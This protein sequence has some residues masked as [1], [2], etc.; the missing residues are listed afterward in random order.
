MISRRNLGIA[1]RDWIL[2]SV[3]SQTPILSLKQ[4]QSLEELIR[5]RP[6]ATTNQFERYRDD[7]V[8]FARDILGVS[9]WEKQQQ[10]ALSVVNNRRTTVRS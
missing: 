7:P 2:M 1:A 10:I 8:G 4:R 6:R 5:R 9:L 3:A